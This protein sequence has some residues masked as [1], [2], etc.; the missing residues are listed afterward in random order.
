MNSGQHVVR[1]AV[2]N[3]EVT[4]VN[5]SCQS[6]PILIIR[7]DI[8]FHHHSVSTFSIHYIVY[9]LYLDLVGLGRHVN[10][11]EAKTS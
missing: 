6:V 7:V 11:S 3:E 8:L 5:M 10:F 1:E 4:E 9:H 2:Y